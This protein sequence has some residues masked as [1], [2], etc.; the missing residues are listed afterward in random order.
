MGNKPVLNKRRIKALKWIVGAF[1]IMMG[2]GSFGNYFLSGVLLVLVGIYILPPIQKLLENRFEILIPRYL[3]YVIVIGVFILAG[4]VKDFEQEGV[5][6]RADQIV[7][8]SITAVS[9]NEFDKAET[10]LNEADKLYNSDNNKASNIEDMLDKF[11]SENFLKKSLVGLSEDEFGKLKQDDLNK[12]FLNNDKLNDLLILKMQKSADSRAEFIKEI[13]AQERLEKERELKEKREAK[14]AAREKK[15]ED[16]FSAWDGSH[17]KL[18]DF[19]KKNMNDPDSYEHVETVYWDRGDFLV[20]KT[21]F[22]GNN[23][24][25]GKVKNSVR[26]KVSLDGEILEIL[27]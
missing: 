2:L 12:K 3:K 17:R 4:F 5:D 15:I 1:T 9:E 21:T 19:I 27:K 16:Q 23:A 10:L 22:R 24:F 6:K 13:E 20:V 11:K 14:A 8:Q 26:A 18:E 25:G 7:Q